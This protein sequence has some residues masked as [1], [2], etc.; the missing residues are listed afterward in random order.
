[1]LRQTARRCALLEKARLVDH[2]HSIVIRQM[3]DD[4]VAHDIAQRISDGAIER[5][6][7]R[8]VICASA[9]PWCA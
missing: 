1:M 9:R 8:C 5:P 6:T 3:L 7:S 2:Q 4:I